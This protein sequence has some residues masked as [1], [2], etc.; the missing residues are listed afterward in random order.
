MKNEE[1]ELKANLKASEELRKRIDDYLSGLSEEER[2]KVET[3]LFN[4]L[5][6]L[7]GLSEQLKDTISKAG[8]VIAPSLSTIV[9]KAQRYETCSSDAEY[10]GVDIDLI[11]AQYH[12]VLSMDDLCRACGIKPAAM[13]KYR[14]GRAVIPADKLIRLSDVSGISMDLLLKQK[15]RTLKDDFVE[16]EIKLMDLDLS[17]M[18][19]TDTNEVFKLSKNLP[20]HFTCIRAY[21]LNQEL[22]VYGVNVKPILVV[23]ESFENPVFYGKEPFLAI[24][25]LD[26]QY[27][28]RQVQRIGRSFMLQ[29]EKGFVPVPV[30]LIKQNISAVV[31]KIVFDF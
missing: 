30:E 25:K 21:R 31:L 14:T 19:H 20:E 8:E 10:T 18:Q 26:D 1:K 4:A 11:L 9:E 16:A 28:I 23:D 24:L 22:S 12:G 7:Q 27:I 17:T 15:Q 5:E 29:L 2:A 13:S 6:P 3:N